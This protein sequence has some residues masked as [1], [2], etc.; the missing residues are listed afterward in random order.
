MF[1]FRPKSII[2]LLLPNSGDH[3]VLLRPEVV[4]RASLDEPVFAVERGEAFQ[5]FSSEL[6]T[7]NAFNLRSSDADF[8][9]ARSIIAVAEAEVRITSGVRKVFLVYMVSF[10]HHSY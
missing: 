8:K 6:Q 1:V 7:R 9:M 3:Q 5:R 10:I 2:R 4:S